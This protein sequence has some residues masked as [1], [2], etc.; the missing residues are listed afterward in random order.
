MLVSL[1]VVLTALP[2]WAVV[3][4]CS[5]DAVVASV[6]W[7]GGPLPA[8]VGDRSM[9][10]ATL[11]LLPFSQLLPPPLYRLTGGCCCHFSKHR[12]PS[13]MLL[14]ILRSALCCPGLVDLQLTLSGDFSW[15]L[16]S[17]PPSSF[18]CTLMSVIRASFIK[19]LSE[20]VGDLMPADL[21]LSE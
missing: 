10:L 7:L 3:V 4:A 17:S 6:L 2:L 1:L 15:L 18:G 12:K 21:G 19:R 20:N 13:E 14:P 5:C 8:A 9:L 16:L 11:V